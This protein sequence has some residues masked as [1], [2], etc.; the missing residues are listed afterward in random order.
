TS[1]RSSGAVARRKAAKDPVTQYARDVVDG[2]VVAGR[3]VRLA[4][5]RHLRDLERGGGGMDR[6]AVGNWSVR[7][8]SAGW[9]TPRSCGPRCGT[10][11]AGITTWSMWRPSSWLATG[12]GGSGRA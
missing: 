12:R 11:W 1:T 9:R 4:C 5:E 10:I 8:T 2:K 7:S 3:L 6:T